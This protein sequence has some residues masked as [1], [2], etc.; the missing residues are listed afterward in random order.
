MARS[1]A[2]AES[3]LEFVESQL[4]DARDEVEAA[5][6]AL[7]AYR[8]KQE[9]VNLELEAEGLLT[10]VTRLE[11]ELESL[12]I[13]EEE[14][15]QRYTENHPVYQQIRNNQEL[16]RQ[17]LDELRAEVDELPETQREIINLTRNLEVAQTVYTELLNRAQELRVLR[18]S[19]IALAMS[20]SSTARGSSRSRLRRDRPGSWR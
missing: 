10:Q 3:S 6:A 20:A 9:S 12:A 8:Q 18:A 7:N 11:N 1:A 14:A 5:E 13:R 4:P 2:E 19:S 17:R 16:V 15:S